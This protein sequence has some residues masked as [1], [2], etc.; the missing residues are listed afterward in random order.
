M[1]EAC[2]GRSLFA[3]DSDKCHCHVEALLEPPRRPTTSVAGSS[4]VGSASG[5]RCVERR[6]N[7]TPVAGSLIHGIASRLRA[8]STVKSV[9]YKD[10]DDEDTDVAENDDAASDCEDL[11]N[12]AD[13]DDCNVDGDARNSVAKRDSFGSDEYCSTGSMEFF[14]R[15]TTDILEPDVGSVVIDDDS[16]GGDESSSDNGTDDAEWNPK[17][18]V[19]RT[20]TKRSR[21]PVCLDFKLKTDP[22]LDDELNAIQNDTVGCD[23][24][25][26]RERKSSAANKIGRKVSL[27]P[28]SLSKKLKH[29][30]HKKSRLQTS[31]KNGV[32]GVR[33]KD[34][35]KWEKKVSIVLLNSICLFILWAVI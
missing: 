11:C 20:R 10:D 9:K 27:A 13:F 32:R 24:S 21:P 8:R 15:M 5:Q 6:T 34:G 33:S 26:S 2:S 14:D 35:P 19:H 22:V 3:G 18:P 7:G 29:V 30:S 25:N 17:K 12:E 16:A 31:A 23:I 1:F 28:R 4:S